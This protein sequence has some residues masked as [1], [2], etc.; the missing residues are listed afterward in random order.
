MAKPLPSLTAARR[1]LDWKEPVGYFIVNTVSGATGLPP[2]TLLNLAGSYHGI[3]LGSALFIL[4]ATLGGVIGLV[5][6]RC[7][8]RG[9]LLRTPWMQRQRSKWEALDRAIVKEG[10][11]KLVALLRL[12]PVIPFM[13]ATVLL[14]L[15]D[16]PL[17]SFIL[18]TA[19]GL[20]PFT[21]VYCYVGSAGRQVLS[22]GLRNPAMLGLT[23][24]GLATTTA[25][26]VKINGVAS[27][28]LE[29]AQA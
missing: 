1:L 9:L 19:L 12:A 26:T 25:L 4:S 23:L 24:A 27:K 13:P 5:L 21:L 28:A 18:G 20:V 8:L 15:T 7:L 16:V 17:P 11:A 3:G 6:V 10:A 2:Q 14:A 29:A 22:G